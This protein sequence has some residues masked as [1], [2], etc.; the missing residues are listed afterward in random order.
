MKLVLLGCVKSP[1]LIRSATTYAQKWRWG[2]KWIIDEQTRQ[3]EREKNDADD[4]THRKEH[5][6]KQSQSDTNPRSLDRF[7]PIRVSHGHGLSGRSYISGSC[8][9]AGIVKLG[10]PKK[11]GRIGTN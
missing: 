11:E 10:S 5:I 6:I 8:N 1:S 4:N 2:H 7:V 3:K 9:H